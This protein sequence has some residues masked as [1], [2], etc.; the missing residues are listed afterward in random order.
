MKLSYIISS[1]L[2]STSV[3]A[4][5]PVSL[6]CIVPGSCIL[7]VMDHTSCIP[8]GG[9]LENCDIPEAAIRCGTCT[10]TDAKKH[11]DI[12][13]IRQAFKGSCRIKGGVLADTPLDLPKC[14]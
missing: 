5:E 11:A 3:S 14:S 12:H 6:S 8:F 1:F 9:F 2:F 10:F 4:T 13:S 7:P